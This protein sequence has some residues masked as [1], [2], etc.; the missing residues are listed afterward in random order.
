MGNNL[1]TNSKSKFIELTESEIVN[2]EIIDEQHLNF[3]NLVEKLFEMLG[4]DKP[5]T[6][7]YL[8]N[9]LAIDLKTH[10]DTEEKFMKDTNYINYFSHKMEH[11]RFLN[12]ILDFKINFE[13]GKE[14]LNLEILK[15]CKNWFHNHIELNDKKLG[16]FL[17]ERNIQ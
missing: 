15:S 5:E 8:V 10:F 13:T 17:A 11:D 3:V 14:K 2:V 4:L 9:Q 7:K 1:K 16:V 12:K 6:I